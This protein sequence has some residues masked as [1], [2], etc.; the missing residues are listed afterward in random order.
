MYS[1]LLDSWSNVVNGVSTLCFV[2]KDELCSNIRLLMAVQ[3]PLEKSVKI[4]P[5]NATLQ[6]LPLMADKW[7]QYHF[8]NGLGISSVVI[9]QVKTGVVGHNVKM[10]SRA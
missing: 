1:T 6:A 7:Y 10:S 8:I 5:G 3:P 4:V 2:F 9:N